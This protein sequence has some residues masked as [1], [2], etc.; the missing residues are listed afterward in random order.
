MNL[1]KKIFLLA[2][3]I[4]LNS[5]KNNSFNSD[6]KTYKIEMKKSEYFHHD[7][8]NH[9]QKT[10]LNL[11][12]ESITLKEIFGILIESDTSTINFEDKK[13]QNQNY[14]ILIKQKDKNI[15]VNEVVLNKIMDELNLKLIEKNYQSFTI[16][17]EDSLKYSNFIK[18]SKNNVSSVTI[19]KDSIKVSNC[20]LNK[21]VE[22]LNSEFSEKITGNNNS[23]R[24]TYQWKKTSF[25]QL[26]I[27]LNN[28]LGLQFL[29]MNTDRITYLIKN[30]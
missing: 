25:E 3:V 6:T 29:N 11:N 1:V 8:T 30:N 23:K 18:E 10:P 28:D 2:L 4:T 5:C 27:Q 19:D 24:I 7:F 16:V 9:I 21:L 17:I 22:V 12:A 13:L 26:K 14:N 20:D 15:P